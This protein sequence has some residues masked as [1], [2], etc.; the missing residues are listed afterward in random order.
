L[1]RGL[2][3]AGLEPRDI[4]NVVIA[5]AD[6]DHIGGL[7]DKM[8]RPIFPNARYVLWQGAWDF[9][10][11][12][13][14]WTDWPEEYIAFVRSTYSRIEDRLEL[15]PSEAEFLPGFQLIAAVGHRYDHIILRISSRGKRFLHIADAVVHPVALAH[16]DWYS[17][18]DTEPEQ[19]V[20][21]KQ[22]LL[23]WS[24]REESLVFGAHFP[25]PGLGA[26]EQRDEGWQWLPVSAT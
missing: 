20:R 26:L 10:F 13:R 15:V 22:W 19:A 18:F 6:R 1:L 3:A 11:S 8:D 25:F 12:E 9:W 2:R 7:L 17:C 4:D 21:T 16:R 5:H 23:D 24:A 14:D